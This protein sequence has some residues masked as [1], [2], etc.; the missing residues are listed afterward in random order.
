M[1][2]LEDA[3][4]KTVH[5]FTKTSTVTQ[6]TVDALNVLGCFK[7]AN[8]KIPAIIRLIVLA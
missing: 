5:A 8:V 3:T 7:D 2:A 6:L 1:P 4:R